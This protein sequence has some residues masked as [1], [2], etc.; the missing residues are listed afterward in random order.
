MDWFW[1]SW[2]DASKK[3]QALVGVK[4]DGDVGPRTIAAINA[5][6][7]AELFAG[8]KAARQNHYNRIIQ[9]N[10]KLETFRKGWANRLNDYNFQP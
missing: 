7:P 5:T 6:P 9:R 10:P 8:I 1:M 3:I 2:D 4:P